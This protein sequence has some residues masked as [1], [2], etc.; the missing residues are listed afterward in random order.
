MKYPEEIIQRVRD[1]ADI[2]ALVGDY[3]PLKKAGSSYKGLCP[4]HSEKTPSFVVSPSRNSFHC[5]GCGKGGNAITF[6]MEMEK[7]PF[8]EALQLLAEKTG[9]PLPKPQETERDLEAE[10]ERDRMFALQEFAGKFFYDQLTTPGGRKAVEY[11]KARKITGETAKKFQIGY[12]PDTWD[13]LKKA[14]LKAKFDEKE[15]LKGG[16]LVQNDEKGRNY[17]K[18]RDRVIFPVRNNF[19]KIIA[20]GGRALGEGPGPKYLNSPET[21]LF[22]KGECLYLLDQAR[23]AIRRE[24]HVLVVEGYFDAVTLHQ[25]DIQHV[26]ATL[27]TA[28]TKEHARQLKRYTQEVVLLYDADQAGQ[29]AAVRGFEPLLSEALRVRVLTLPDAKDPDEYLMKHSREE[30][31]FLLKGAPEFFRWRAAGLR[32]KAKGR[33]VEELIRSVQSLASFLLRVPDEASVQ[34]ACAAIEGELGLDNFDMRAIVNAERKSGSRVGPAERQA[35]VSK[36]APLLPGREVEG[37]FLALLVADRAEY[38]KWAVQSVSPDL[39]IEEDLKVLFSN[40][41]QGSM[42]AATARMAPAL[43]PFFM[44]IE[45][46]PDKFQPKKT[47][48]TQLYATLEMRHRKRQMILVKE[49]LGAAE[50]AGEISKAAELAGRFVELKNQYHEM[51]HLKSEPHE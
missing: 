25:N 45:A 20:F 10:R 16:L 7:I 44:Q 1:A 13:A 21:P 33:P 28:L 41:I 31:I 48:I 34:A 9:I 43:E 46:Q 4:F 24:G 17:D 18:F 37:E 30:L 11:L 39:F 26:V 49:E 38:V 5:F 2:V 8:P 3:V 40:L 51:N 50:K 19:G 15:L 6:L 29:D 47:L 27:G 32:E 42:D 23:D 22:K 12:A 35:P 36:V 14:A